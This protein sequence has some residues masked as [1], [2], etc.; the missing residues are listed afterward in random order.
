M[1]LSH[2]NRDE[3]WVCDSG[4]QERILTCGSRLVRYMYTVKVMDAV[5][6]S[7]IAREK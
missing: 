5:R 7:K 4:E 6:V 2:P 3:N 1:M